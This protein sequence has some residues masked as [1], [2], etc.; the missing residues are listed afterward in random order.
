MGTVQDG[1]EGV[2]REEVIKGMECCRNGF[3]LFCPYNEHE[4][5]AIKCKSDL[6]ADALALLKAQEIEPGYRRG[7]PFCG[8]CGN[9]L[10]KG[11]TFCRKCGRK[12]KWE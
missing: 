2:T 10:D 6:N 8:G 4:I 12:V 5:D 7:K 3:C 1:G 11:D 9:S